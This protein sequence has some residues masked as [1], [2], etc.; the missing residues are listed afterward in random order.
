MTNNYSKRGMYIFLI[1]LAACSA[2]AFQ[3]WRTLLNNFAVDVAGLDGLDMGIVQSV[4]EVPGF[5]SLLAI[6]AILIVR[7][8][9]LAAL[10]VIVL[11]IG[12]SMAGLLP[13]TAGLVFTTLLMSFGFHF[14]MTMN[15][16]LTLQYFNHTEAPMVMARVRSITA[17]ANVLVGGLIYFLARRLDYEPLF[18]IMG[19][20]AVA[21]GLWALTRD[22]SSPDVPMQ[23][24]KLEFRSRY[25]LFYALT[26]LS[27]A[28]RQIFTAFAVYLMVV[29]F[30]FSVEHVTLLFIINNVL[31]YFVNPLIG[32]AVNRYGERVVLTIEYVVLTVVFLG[33]AK[34]ESALLVSFFYVADNIV[35]NFSMAINTFYQKLADPRDI[36]SGMAMGF[37]VNHIAAVAVPFLGGL[38]WM[39]DYHI[40]FLGAA[41]LS[42]LSLI[43]SQFIPG[44]LRKGQSH[45]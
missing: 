10:S 7:E 33:Y 28:R 9:R 26:F 14:Y 39:A 4:R 3:G 31:N 35:F 1:V 21:C 20:V 5:L 19:G 29:K 25:W 43:L 40:V 27:G 15:Q 18:A 22:P 44:Q 41:G 2:V 17:L 42:L 38:A 23:R 12:V 24:K 13:T 16:S 6:Y 32:R 30:K 8:H 11:G 45:S 36:A 34:T 37:T